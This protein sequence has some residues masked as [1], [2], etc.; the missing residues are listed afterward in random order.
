[1]TDPITNVTDPAAAATD[2]NAVAEFFTPLTEAFQSL[3]M[4]ESVMYTL[5]LACLSVYTLINSRRKKSKGSAIKSLLGSGLLLV[6]A[7]FVFAKTG[8]HDAL[9]WE[10]A[11]ALLGAFVGAR[12]L[13]Q[14]WGKDGIAQEVKGRRYSY[15]YERYLDKKRPIAGVLMSLLALLT[16]AGAAYGPGIASDVADSYESWSADNVVEAAN[17][18]TMMKFRGDLRESLNTPVFADDKS[19]ATQGFIF[20]S[21]EELTVEVS[22]RMSAMTERD[23][24]RVHI[25]SAGGLERSFDVPVQNID[26]VKQIISL[27]QLKDKGAE[28]ED[29]VID[30]TYS[31]PRLSI[32]NVIDGELHDFTVREIAKPELQPLPSTVKEATVNDVPVTEQANVPNVPALIGMDLSQFVQSNYLPAQSNGSNN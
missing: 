24:I 23:V 10:N 4:P 21:A 13:P 6:G 2:S 27:K 22:S 19:T 17:A 16:G 30:V 32:G 14:I 3:N 9:G 20:V 18:E 31:N 25:E 11:I 26:E 7:I 28:I 5:P 8:I 15:R 12:Q 29:L 1:M